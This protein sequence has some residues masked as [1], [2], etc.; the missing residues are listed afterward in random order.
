MRDICIGLGLLLAN[1]SVMDAPASKYDRSNSAYLRQFA[2]RLGPFNSLW[3]IVKNEGILFP[4]PSTGDT[5]ESTTGV[6]E[7]VK[8][9]Q[10]Q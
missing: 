3:K 6:E 1:V 8:Q 7:E 4:K 10:Q 2:T 5:A 9:Q